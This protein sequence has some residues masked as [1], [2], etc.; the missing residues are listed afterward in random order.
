MK[1]S[2]FIIALL[3]CCHSGYSQFKITPHNFV[4]IADSLN[5]YIVIDYTGMPKHEL[6]KKAKIYVTSNFKGIKYDGYNE[7]EDELIV[8]DVTIDTSMQLFGSQQLVEL[9]NRI[10]LRFKDNK[11][12][13]SPTFQ[14]L[15]LPYRGGIHKIPLTGGVAFNPSVFKSNGKPY[16]ETP[17]IIENLT[18]EFINKLTSNLNKKDTNW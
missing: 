13:I 4:S 9:N 2:I 15:S 8:L 3:I 18:N 11:L 17:Q 5:D 6:F 1:I 10:E 14:D 7:V 16:K 12:R